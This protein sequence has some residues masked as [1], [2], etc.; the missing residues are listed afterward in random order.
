M[1]DLP[2]HCGD[3]DVP[4]GP[5]GYMLP[6][7]RAMVWFAVGVF[8]AWLVLI[9]QFVLAAGELL[10][11]KL[12]AARVAFA[13]QAG[14]LATLILAAASLAGWRRAKAFLELVP[15]RDGVVMAAAMA[16]PLVVLMWGVGIAWQLG[17]EWLGFEFGVP[18]NIQIA[19][20]SAAGFLLVAGGALG[21]APFCEEVLFRSWLFE[22]VKAYLGVPAAWVAAAGLFVA[23]HLSWAQAPQLLILA[24]A[25]QW[26]RRR[27]RSL[28]PA[29]V[30]HFCNNLITLAWLFWMTA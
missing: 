6:I 23:I 24:L 27:Y 29:V 5:G 11:V 7:R 25:L 14:L 21:F 9:P 15:S 1:D 2:E 18:L 28:W 4:G 22:G 10:G 8:I 12:A 30:L 17:G 20:K 26:V 3:A 16:V 13:C 19:R